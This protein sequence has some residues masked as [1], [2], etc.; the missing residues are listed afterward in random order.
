MN[1]VTKMTVMIMRISDISK[2][3]LIHGDYGSDGSDIQIPGA[4]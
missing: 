1:L 2:L 3:V 4:A